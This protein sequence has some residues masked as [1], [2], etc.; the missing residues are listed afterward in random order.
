MGLDAIFAALPSIFGLG[1]AAAGAAGAA[2]AADVAASAFPAIDAAGAAGLST[3]PADIAAGGAVDA[4]ALAGG[5]AGLAGT[6]LAGGTDIASLA[7]GTAGLGALGT[8]A[9]VAGTAGGLT[10]AGLA[11][12][13]AGAAFGPAADASLQGSLSSGL[14]SIPS[15]PASIADLSGA[16]PFAAGGVSTTA[17]GNALPAN[18]ANANASLPSWASTGGPAGG[19]TIPATGGGGGAAAIAGPTG[20]VSGVDPTA[21]GPTSA[22]NALDLQ[23]VNGAVPAGSAPAGS[24][25]GISDLISKAAGS[26]TSNPLQ[27][28]GVAAGLGGL[29]YNIYEGQQLTKNQQALAAAAQTQANTGQQAFQAGLPI[30]NANNATG[31]GLINQG[32][33]LQTYLTSGTL[34]PQYMTQ[35]NQAIQSAKTNAISQAAS[36]GQSTDPTKNSVLAAQLA[37]IDNQTPA[38]ITQVANTLFSAGTSDVNA[39]SG[40]TTSSAGSLLG[41]GQGA[42]GLSNQLYQTLVQND[43]TQAA[44]TGK[45]IASLAAALNGKTTNT[46]GNVTTQV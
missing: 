43:T 25:G 20:S 36:S 39:G 14:S 2:G 46:A 11:G 21:L 8:A 18:V 6:A 19:T 1:D 5:T 22:G 16:Q 33:A 13:A 10:A 40:L 9:D 45:A 31:T 32:E 29:G 41:A 44:N 30:A 4:S 42:S 38:M 27:A 23:S 35:I 24:G 3:I 34:P 15:A 12:D 26:I 37:E 28:A 17:G 7:G